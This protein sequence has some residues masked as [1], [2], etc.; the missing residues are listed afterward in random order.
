MKNK[1]KVLFIF[2]FLFL[3][4]FVKELNASILFDFNNIIK[5]EEL[6]TNSAGVVDENLKR[7]LNKELNDNYSY[8]RPLDQDLTISD[9][10]IFTGELDLMDK[11]IENISGLE[12][13]I[14]VESINLNLNNITDITP[15]EGMVNLKK[16]HLINNTI[17]DISPIKD[18]KDLT[19]LTLSSNNIKDIT[20]L[21][22]LDNLTNLSLQN[23]NISNIESLK[24]LSSLFSLDISSNQ[25]SDLSPLKGKNIL[26]LRATDQKI[27][28][29]YENSIHNQLLPF[30]VYDQ[31]GNLHEIDL[32][33]PNEGIHDYNA[34]WDYSI[35]T[36][37]V[38]YLNYGYNPNFDDK[39]SFS[40]DDNKSIKLHEIQSDEDL[41]KLFNVRD[42]KDD[43][44]NLTIDDIKVDQSNIDYDK[45]GV[46]KVL[47]SLT[48]SDLNKTIKEVNLEVVDPIIYMPDDNL[49]KTLNEDYFSQVS[50][51]DITQ[52]QMENLTELFLS[53]GEVKDITGLEYAQNINTL[54]LNYNKIIDLTPLSSLIN[55]EDLQFSNNEISD[56]SPLS[57]LINLNTL[58]LSSNQISDISPLSGLKNLVNL[59]LSYN[60]VSDISQLNGLTNL[61]A[62][63]LISNQI[64]D[65]TV[66]N[67]LTNLVNVDLSSNQISD[68]SPLSGLTNLETLRLINNHLNNITPLSGLTNLVNLDLSSNQINDITVLNRLTNLVN[69]DLSSN[70]I[71]DISPLSGLTNLETLGLNSNQINDII[72]LSGLTNL[73]TLELNSNQINDI[74][75]LSGLT[76]LVNLKMI[77]NQISDLRPLKNLSKIFLDVGVQKIDED[78]GCLGTKVAPTFVTYD[79]DG[80]EYEV[81]MNDPKQG[82]HDYTGNWDNGKNSGFG[83][84]SGTVNYT[85]YKYDTVAPDL[86]FDDNKS[87]PAQKSLS[88]EELK[89]LFNV[90]AI[91]FVEG[92]LTGDVVVDQ[93]AVK[94]DVPGNYKVTFSVSDPTGNR[95]SKDAN[96]EV[97]TL[98]PTIS[99]DDI[100][101]NVDSISGVDI[102]EFLLN[103]ANIIVGET[104][105]KLNDVVVKSTNLTNDSKVGIYDAKFEVSNDLLESASTDIKIYVGSGSDIIDDTNPYLFANDIIVDTCSKIDNS[106][107]GAIA[108][109]KDD[110][111]LRSAIN[112]PNVDTST[113]GKKSA[114]LSVSDK[115]GNSSEVSVN[116]D[117]IDNIKP[118]IVANDSSEIEVNSTLSS[119]EAKKLFKVSVSDNVDNLTVDDVSVDMSGV[120]L[121]TVGTYDIIFSVSDKSSNSTTKTS[122]LNVIDSDV[123]I[124]NSLDSQSIKAK[125][126]LSDEELKS[127]FKVS[128]SDNYDGDITSDVVV[129]QTKVNYDVPGIYDVVFSVVDSAGNRV[130]KKVLLKVLSNEPPVLKGVEDIEVI[131]GNDFDLMDGVSAIDKEDGDI[132][133]NIKVYS[134][135]LKDGL[136]QVYN[137][138]I[139]DSDGNKV[140]VNR[141]VK[142]VSTVTNNKPV[143]DGVDNKDILVGED[144]NPMDGVSSSDVEDGDLTSSISLSG[145]INNNVPGDY[146]L[147]YSVVDSDN[148]IVSVDR[149][150][151]VKDIV[152][153]TNNKP[154]ISGANDVKVK[155]NT[156]FD[157]MEGIVASDIEDGDL[158]NN[159]IVVR[160]ELDTSIVGDY[161][162]VYSVIDSDS[163]ISNVSRNISV[164]DDQN[165]INDSEVDINDKVNVNNDNEKLIETG[166][167]SIYI[168]CISVL[169]FL[170]YFLQIKKVNKMK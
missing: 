135:D 74:T 65:I 101:T 116:V 56:I 48:D 40:I 36:G 127:L 29:D 82:V 91:D 24:N 25:I 145:S 8:T 155:L 123:P 47:F 77:S 122:K 13:A 119:D 51:A 39:P 94:Y 168:L 28:K 2:I 117:V 71:S 53:N 26:V 104:T 163:N 124:I 93:S 109:D 166:K 83:S 54:Y 113:V 41:K 147:T 111:D 70:Q 132:S 62:L 42:I 59:D 44:D 151:S 60:K 52:S 30:K 146:V 66:L 85:N 57:G 105:K 12:Y 136:T 9:M 75:P 97:K 121:D 160:N 69:V 156:D 133:N 112:Y 6:S 161:K 120:D 107:Y 11:E 110:G 3:S 35:F 55:L 153:T 159:I 88:D 137:Y 43:V 22:N 143:I 99:A 128:A 131:S 152:V 38:D 150:I 78:F 32:G 134:K 98:Y 118:V 125:K 79:I 1:K 84:F 20:A 141:T 18:L 129:N 167:N 27:V 67:R 46:Y 157:I 96:L 115:D 138:S 45:G 162:I 108:F 7:A 92:D 149:T 33:T 58:K 34:N 73:E 158:S 81:D 49:R 139:T 64:N 170:T 87:T 126:I 76:N 21:E 130:D 17:E 100:Y 61:E 169:S 23:N 63:E 80:K 68:I 10:G 164:Y 103:N 140:E 165:K 114:K 148:N 16:L 19:E 106:L 50:D 14:N 142:Y 5:K 102:D 95:V 4:I 154:I 86:K 31:Y 89:S 90:S 72:P 15:V 144:F 37:S